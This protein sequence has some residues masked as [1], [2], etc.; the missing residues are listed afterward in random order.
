MIKMY[1]ASV[2][3]YANHV[4]MFLDKLV[5]VCGRWKKTIYIQASKH[6]YKIYSHFNECFCVIVPIAVIAISLVLTANAKANLENKK[7][8]TKNEKGKQSKKKR[9]NE[10]KEEIKYM[11]KKSYE[12]I[13]RIKWSVVIWCAPSVCYIEVDA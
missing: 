2:C 13:V 6:E 12:P 3:L 4:C 9:E 11:R 7:K 8:T 5:A 1:V 10:T